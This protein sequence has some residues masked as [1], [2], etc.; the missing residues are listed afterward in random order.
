[1]TIIKYHS[2]ILKLQWKNKYNF[3]KS[4]IRDL[5]K[6]VSQVLCIPRH[7]AA[8]FAFLIPRKKRN[9]SAEIIWPNRETYF[10]GPKISEFFQFYFLTH[11]VFNILDD[12]RWLLC[13]SILNRWL[14]TRCAQ[15]IFVK[16]PRFL[17]KSNVFKCC[18][19]LSTVDDLSQC[20]LIWRYCCIVGPRIQ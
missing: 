3:E 5:T 17:V 20:L 2:K 6:C 13:L 4:E 7:V 18:Q 19:H 1:M 14:G 8:G 15:Y 12:I 16:F 9:K 11:C 10:Y